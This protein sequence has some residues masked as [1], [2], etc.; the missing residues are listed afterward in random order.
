[1]VQAVQES[2]EQLGAV[3]LVV[4]GGVVVLT[5]QGGPELDAGL[6]E[7]AGLADGL[8]RAVEFGWAGAVAVAEQAVVFAAQPGH[9]GVCQFNGS[10]SLAV[11]TLG[12][13]SAEQDAVA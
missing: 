5:L 4:L 9:A 3:G 10:V 7:G 12:E 11:V 2:G 1:M 6:E 8:E 13:C